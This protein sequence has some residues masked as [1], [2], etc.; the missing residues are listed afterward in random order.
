MSVKVGRKNLET[1]QLKRNLKTLCTS[2][3]IIKRTC[4]NHSCRSFFGWP[5]SEHFNWL[6]FVCSS[7]L[8]LPL[9]F[10]DNL[11]LRQ[12]RYT[13]MLETVHIRQSGYSCKY[14]FQV[15]LCFIS[16]KNS[17]YM[18][19]K[20]VCL[21]RCGMPFWKILVKYRVKYMDD[22]AEARN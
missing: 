21:V 13:G 9:R 10:N 19:L 8:K 17:S 11:V 15:R 14:S 4:S 1:M 3:I 20:D 7:F 16:S 22:I 5:C 12:L 6:A 2:P 18:V